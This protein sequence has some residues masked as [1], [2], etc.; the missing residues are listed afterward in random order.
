MVKE[1]SFGQILFFLNSSYGCLP[2]N[3]AL[4]AYKLNFNIWLFY[5][6]K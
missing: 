2:S 1:V 5:K 4:V 6:R 3:F